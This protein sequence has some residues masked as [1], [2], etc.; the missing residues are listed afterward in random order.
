MMKERYF[1]NMPDIETQSE[2]ARSG[3]AVD[4]LAFVEAQ[5][6][7]SAYFEEQ[8]Y[9]LAPM[10]GGES[11][12]ALLREALRETGKIGIAYVVIQSRQHLAAL[13]PQG[14]S[15]ILNTLRWTAEDG[16]PADAPGDDYDAGVPT[17][18]GVH[19][20][21]AF[22]SEPFQ[23]HSPVLEEHI[24]KSKKSSEHIVV[25]ELEALL[26]DDELFDEDYQTMMLGRRTHS[27]TGYAIRRS[28]PVRWNTRTLMRRRGR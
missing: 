23:Y 21:P 1:V 15:L 25:E 28:H 9:Y 8:P 4:I 19:A 11:I 14:Q 6:I 27:S 22:H 13:I 26:E 2:P 10:P 5:E 12:Y 24:M 17:G 16:S 20:A 3:H 7:P 18:G